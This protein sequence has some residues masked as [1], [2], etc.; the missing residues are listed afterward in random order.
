MDEVVEV[1]VFVRV[2]RDVGAVLTAGGVRESEDLV[3][4]ESSV[5]ERGV[6]VLLARRLPAL[7]GLSKS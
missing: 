3:R 1:G 5:K 2:D 6:K 7:D 4:S